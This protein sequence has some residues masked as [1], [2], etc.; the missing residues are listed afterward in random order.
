MSEAIDTQAFAL[1]V[2]NVTKKQEDGLYGSK[3]LDGISF[4]FEKKGIH[5]ILAPKGSGKTALMDII[6]GCDSDYEGEVLIFGDNVKKNK[7]MKSRIG[8]VQKVSSFYPD[9][10]AVETM[11]FVGETRRV[12]QGKLYRQI[13]EAMELVGIDEIKNRLV[14]NM[15]DFEQKKLSIAVAL[16]GNPD[17]L[18]LD[19]T[20]S[21]KMSVERMSELDGIIRM[22]GRV[23]T[24]VLATDDYGLAR[25]LCDDVVILS[26]GRVL[27]KGS[28]AALDEKLA[29]SEGGMTLETLYNSLASAN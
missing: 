27:A 17:I 5:G 10:T 26:D 19:E 28:F 7:N 20:V 23:K 15:T 22:L 16:L 3:G 8:Y 1:F 6:S 13:K 18:L 2:D 4:C 11:S 14:K 21:A 25:A 9:M 12:D 24:V 29:R